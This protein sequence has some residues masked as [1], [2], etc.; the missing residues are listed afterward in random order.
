MITYYC[1]QC[2][3]IVTEQ[4]VSCPNCGYHLGQF[5]ELPYE[6]KLL[7]GLKHPVQDIRIIAI[8]AL[9]DLGNLRAIPEFKQIV[10]NENEDYYVLRAVLLALEIIPGQQSI[11]LLVQAKNH[12]SELV[13]RLAD[14]ILKRMSDQD[15]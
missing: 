9:G 6:D 10:M 5:T 13:R 11:A 14:Q 4:D 8:K 7:L 12:P 3:T 1:P 15:H 2:W